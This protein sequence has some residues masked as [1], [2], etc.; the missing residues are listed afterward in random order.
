MSLSAALLDLVLPRRCVGCRRPGAALCAGCLPAGPPRV[1]A[2]GVFAATAYE[3]AVRRALLGYKE[4]GRRDLAGPLAGLLA[5]AVRAAAEA[6][7]ASPGRTLLVPVPSARSVAAGRGG[8]HV[9]R[10]TR[11]AAVL[12]GWRS[13]PRVL[14]LTRAV[15]DSAGL[16][17]AQRSANMAGAMC[18]RPARAGW[19]VLVVDDIVTTGATVREA[20]RALA[21]AG[22]P[23]AGA[24]VVAATPRRL[25]MR[26]PVLAGGSARIGSA[27]P[28]GLA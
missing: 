9:V 20:C 4:R 22:W 8:D 13:A 19:T 21:A 25:P 3:N 15:R 6:G 23:V 12:G 1:A 7:R 17:T 10:L 26:P 11:R 5:V 27:H 2:S 18:A 24:A 14:A 16:D 28:G